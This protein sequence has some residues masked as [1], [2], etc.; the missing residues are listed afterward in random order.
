MSA[1]LLLG[2]MLFVIHALHGQLA[3]LTAAAVEIH[4]LI[5][6]AL[7]LLATLTVLVTASLHAEIVA[8]TGSAPI[9]FARVRYAYAASQVARYVPGKVFGV[10]LETQ[11]LAPAVGVGQVVTATL[12]QT[13]L[14]YAWA[15]AA[16]VIILGTLGLD[17]AWPGLLAP[18]VLALLWLAQR[19][20]W[21]ER[22]RSTLG[23]GTNATP[24]PA[25]STDSSRRSARRSTLLLA[26]QWLPFFAMWIL[27]AAADHGIAAASWLG[28][29]YLLAS[30]GGSLLVLVPSGLVVREAAFV[31]LGGLYGLP[32]SSLVAWAVVVRL[33]LTFADVLAVP[34]LW[35]VS[36]LR[37]H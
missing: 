13:L 34:V 21:P 16:A 20:R 26:I 1:L 25:R 3:D 4:P 5:F 37:A 24:A 27:L 32:A 36:R 33:A 8:R 7:A 19:N 11:M 30:I 23:T 12:L 15:G 28:A 18:V 2:G 35:I 17:S 22:M 10:L 29:S 14:A 9:D 6:P 31:W